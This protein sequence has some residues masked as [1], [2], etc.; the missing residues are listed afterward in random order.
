MARYQRIDF[1][2]Y[3]VFNGGSYK[4]ACSVSLLLNSEQSIRQIEDAA[5][6]MFALNLVDL[7]WRVEQK[8]YETLLEVI[9][10]HYGL[11]AYQVLLNKKR[12]YG[13]PV[14]L[15]LESMNMV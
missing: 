2:G 14:R 7:E 6:K 8:N 5:K 4:I 9:K 3:R 11:E 10:E 1:V 13:R 12:L 15:K